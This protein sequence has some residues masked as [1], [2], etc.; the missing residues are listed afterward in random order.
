MNTE[1]KLMNS[2][3]MKSMWLTF[4]VL[5][6][7]K[8]KCKDLCNYEHLPCNY[9]YTC[10]CQFVCCVSS[11]KFNLIVIVV[12]I[13]FVVQL[14]SDLVII[15]IERGA[16]T[17]SKITHAHIR[18][19]DRQAREEKWCKQN[20]TQSNTQTNPHRHVTRTVCLHVSILF[21]SISVGV[22]VHHT[23]MHIGIWIAL[24]CVFWPCHRA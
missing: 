22:H 23:W 10:K 3:Q 12:R 6:K 5:P 2:P 24:A 11:C 19:L 18:V 13:R 9:W 17:L 4:N 8:T 20:K 7:T 15:N 14:C 1:H 16:S 21:W